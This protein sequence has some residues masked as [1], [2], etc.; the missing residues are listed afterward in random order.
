MLDVR[1]RFKI[2]GGSG[3]VDAEY[4]SDPCNSLVEPP[5]N[6]DLNRNLLIKIEEEHL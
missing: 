3:I 6:R 4:R 2:E 1:K 5:Q